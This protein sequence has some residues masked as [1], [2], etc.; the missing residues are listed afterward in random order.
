LRFDTLQQRANELLQNGRKH[1]TKKELSSA[2]RCVLSRRRVLAQMDCVNNSIC[3]LDNH[4]SV[5]D[6]MDLD[7]TV[8]RT[9]RASGNA[10]KH[11][12][13]PGGV[14]AIDDIMV[15]VEE[16]MN[17][18]SELAKAVGSGVLLQHDEMDA[19]QLMAELDLIENDSC[20]VDNLPKYP[21]ITS[22]ESE[23]VSQVKQ[24]DTASPHLDI[25]TESRP[26]VRTPAYTRSTAHNTVDG[27]SMVQQATKNGMH[28][29]PEHLMMNS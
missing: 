16:Q 27:V 19:E 5:L 20:T 14:S 8:L 2:K 10:L 1:M 3:A 21:G 17:E 24:S 28:E 9:L 13:I 25:A 7:M 22:R 12:S 23:I 18:A 11:M 26:L 6:G 29:F 4:L 15:S